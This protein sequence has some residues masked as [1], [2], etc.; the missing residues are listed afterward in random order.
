[1]NFRLRSIFIVFTLGLLVSFLAS[2]SAFAADA[3]APAGSFGC[4]DLE[5][6]FNE[7]QKK[8]DLDVQLQ[9]FR[10]QLR[11]RLELRNNNKLLTPEE[12]TKLTELST[13]PNAT[14][15]EK[16]QVDDM[17]A[18]SKTLDQE[19]QTLQQKKDAT[20]ADKARFAVLQDQLTKTDE[21]LKEDAN[22][23]QGELQS[24]MVELSQQVMVDISK[25]VETVAKEK[26]LSVVFNKTSGETI[27]V[28]YSS[29]DITND[30][31]QKLNKK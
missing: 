29:I 28:V 15:D 18:R 3:K 27:L 1:M 26:N 10:D 21:T 14:A 23:F 9:S 13:K 12:Y 16:K 24:K 8:K 22:K 5:K 4:V 2:G 20:D 7:S 25:T 6:V 31:I 19:Y 11:L 30:V 17:I